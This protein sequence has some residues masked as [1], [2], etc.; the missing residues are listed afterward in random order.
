MVEPVVNATVTIWKWCG[1]FETKSIRIQ[2]WPESEDYSK[3]RTEL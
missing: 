3:V 2:S 1:I